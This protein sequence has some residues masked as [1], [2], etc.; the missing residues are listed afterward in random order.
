MREP[1]RGAAVLIGMVC[2]TALLALAESAGAASALTTLLEEVAEQAKLP[3]PVRADGTI[4]SD[5]LEGKKRDRVVLVQRGRKDGE[6]R[7]G[8]IG[9]ETYLELVDSKA[10]VLILS[11]AETHRLEKGK[12]STA[13]L[14][15]RIA[16]TSATIEDLLAF[17]PARCHDTH[18]IDTQPGSMTV[19]CEPKKGTGSQYVLAVWKLDRERAVPTQVLFYQERLNNLVK[20]VRFDDQVLVGDRWRPRKILVQDFPLRTRDIVTLTWTQDPKIAPELFDPA[21]LGDP[22]KVAPPEE[23]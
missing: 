8:T 4:Q 14:D 5:S 7:K 6:I 1:L 11:P 3:A 21:S 16:F 13:N 19:R 18:V 15:S 2:V 22:S 17:D 10:R 23:P 12:V 9:T 20:L